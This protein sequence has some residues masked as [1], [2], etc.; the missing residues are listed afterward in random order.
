MS[1]TSRATTERASVASLL[2]VILVIGSL[3]SIVI[4][5][6]NNAAASNVLFKERLKGIA[7]SAEKTTREG[8]T[9][10]VVAAQAFTTT[11][12]DTVLCVF[13]IKYDESTF[14]NDLEGCAA[15]QQLTVANGLSSATFSGTVTGF[16][17]VSGEEK[18]V[19]V[20]ADLTATGKVQT[21]TSGSHFSGRGFTEVTHFSG[22]STAA[23]GSLNIGGDITFSIDDA[24]GQISNIKSGTIQVT[25]N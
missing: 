3:C 14:F 19:T 16:D 5:L 22:M 6:S 2:T 23:S 15:G 9:T 10:T 7:A 18:T 17:F 1:L 8:S 4:M 11:G 20:N 12:G 24:T 21:S 13:V 25:K